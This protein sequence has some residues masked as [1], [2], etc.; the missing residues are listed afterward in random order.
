[1]HILGIDPGIGITGYGI[2]DLNGPARH[3]SGG[4]S[5]KLVEAGIIKTSA[6]SP[7][8][9][10]LNKIYDNIMQII[11][12]FKPQ[13]LVLEEL[14]SHYKH[15]TT[16][17]TMAHARAVVCLACEKSKV[18]LNGYSAKRIRKAIAGNGNASKEQIQRVVSGILKL[19]KLPEPL[20]VTDALALAIGHAY[21]SKMNSE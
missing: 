21:I 2:I 18:S 14:Y 17:I 5:I 3:H 4:P 1:M 16:V 15:P 8:S 6:K 19:N 10:R 7:L 20:D 13:D 12:E 9:L 11:D